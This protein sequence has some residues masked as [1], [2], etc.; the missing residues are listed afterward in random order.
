MAKLFS[1]SPELQLDN[2]S[3]VQGLPLFIF[4]IVSDIC[5]F[6]IFAFSSVCSSIT[7][8]DCIISFFFPLI[9]HSI[10]PQVSERGRLKHQWDREKVLG[11]LPQSPTGRGCISA[12]IS[13]LKS[14][15]LWSALSSC[16]SH[17]GFWNCSFP[18]PSVWR[19]LSPLRLARAGTSVHLYSLSYP[20]IMN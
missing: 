8:Q 12:F 13:L 15:A 6:L 19:I 16:G 7:S 14:T 4:L 2:R 18:F 3:K 20:F 5:L 9:S 17:S 1:V 10:F 11:D